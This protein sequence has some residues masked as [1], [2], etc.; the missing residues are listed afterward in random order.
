MLIGGARWRS[1]IRAR[2][3]IVEV[4]QLSQR[5]VIGW[6]TTKKKFSSRAPPC[7]GRHVKP[8]VPA[9][10]AVVNNHQ[11]ALGPRDGLRPDLPIHP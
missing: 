5:P 3:A 6:V 11:S 8:L 9:A 7:F 4:K 1:G 10:L 2:S